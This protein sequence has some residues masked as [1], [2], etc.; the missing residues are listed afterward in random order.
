MRHWSSHLISSIAPQGHN[1]SIATA[2]LLISFLLFF[3]LPPGWLPLHRLCQ[4]F[5]VPSPRRPEVGG[6]G[7]LFERW[8]KGKGLHPFNAIAIGFPQLFKSKAKGAATAVLYTPF[9][10][11]LSL[12]YVWGTYFRHFKK[13]SIY[14]KTQKNQAK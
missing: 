11:M 8:R 12:R 7:A 3:D 6:G 14:V 10:A 2:F 9:N 1:W 13:L 5:R 4:V